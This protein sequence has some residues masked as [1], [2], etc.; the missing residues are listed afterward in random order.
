MS[1][2]PG[3]F[4]VR[5]PLYAPL[6]T[7]QLTKELARI[8]SPLE[9]HSLTYSAHF[10]EMVRENETAAYI[11]ILVSFNLSTFVKPWK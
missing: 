5:A 6:T 4:K 10:V 3:T 8:L 2:E 9:G 7:Y 1:D 11:D